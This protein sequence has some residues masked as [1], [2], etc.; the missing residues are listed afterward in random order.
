MIL[1]CSTTKNVSYM[2]IIKY[3]MCVVR[4]AV[5]CIVGLK[6]IIR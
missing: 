6:E 5:V 4:I 3:N 2:W 1:R